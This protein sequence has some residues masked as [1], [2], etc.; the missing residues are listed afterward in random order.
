MTPESPFPPPRWPVWLGWGVLAALVLV[1]LPLLLCM[2]LWPDVS[3]YDVCARN[4]LDGGVPYR[5][6]FD[7]NL[8][9]VVWMH[10][11][12]RGLLGWRSEFLHGADFLIVAAVVWLLARWLGAVGCSPVTQVWTA[13]VLLTFYF[14]TSEFA[15]CQRDTWMLLPALLALHL[16]RRQVARLAGPE[17]EPRL[18]VRWGMVEGVCWGAALWIKPHMALPALLCWLMSAF[19]IGRLA[20][21]G[22]GRRVLADLAGLLAGGVAA[23]ALGVAWLSETGAWPYFVNVFLEW[24]REYFPHTP[25]PHRALVCLRVLLPWSLVH[26]VAVPRAVFLIAR[27]MAASAEPGQPARPDAQSLLAGL[28]L[29]WLLQVVLLQHGFEYVQVPLVLLG[30][31]LVAGWQ[32]PDWNLGWAARTELVVR[33]LVLTGFLGWAAATHPMFRA[34]RV[35]CWLECLS[36]GSSPRVRER[37]KLRPTETDWVA[38]DRVA[39]FLREQ[40]LGP[41]ELTCYDWRTAALYIELDLKPSTRFVFLNSAFLW[42]P[43]HREAIRRAVVSSSQRYVVSDLTFVGYSPTQAAAGS[44]DRPPAL[45]P[46]FPSE[47]KKVFPWSEPVV[48][49]AGRYAVHEV[50]S[51][52]IRLWLEASAK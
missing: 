52:E 8:P 49:R 20:E 7:N 38:L 16:R 23:G 30:L 45:P 18:A 37:L 15:Q 29:G 21:E 43:R 4:V 48:F 11:L 3:L 24:N 31:T 22:G 40:K 47:V 32:W 33:W 12:I 26:L 36:E 1:N 9:G 6:A 42:F 41:G 13:A 19:Q 2:P 17:A 5:D 27:G 14:S 50:T 34:Q 44:R 35:S 10:A 46:N 25:I 39:A 51:K 28:Y